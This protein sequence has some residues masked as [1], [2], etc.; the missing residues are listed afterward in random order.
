[1]ETNKEETYTI[2]G[3]W[4]GDPDRNVISYQ[5][6]IGQALLGHGVGETISLNSEHGPAQFAIVSIQP[7]PPDQ[8]APPRT[9]PTESA[10]EA[11]ITG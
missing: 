3:A 1:V 4:D 9:L 7:A 8:T 6:A 10:V 11:A 2:L 5:T